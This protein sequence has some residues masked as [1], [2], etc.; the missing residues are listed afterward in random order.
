[1]QAI[2]E[3]DHTHRPNGHFSLFGT[4]TLGRV[5]QCRRTLL[6]WTPDLGDR[7]AWLE[8]LRAA[9]CVREYPW[10]PTPVTVNGRTVWPYA[11]IDVDSF[12]R[13]PAAL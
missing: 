1:V 2:P 13:K 4:P 10:E 12:E 11:L 5:R 8:E 9:G 3:S 6:H 7:D